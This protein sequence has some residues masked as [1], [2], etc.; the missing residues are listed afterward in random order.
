MH[1]SMCEIVMVPSVAF[2]SRL[3]QNRRPI[4]DFAVDGWIYKEGKYPFLILFFR[5]VSVNTEMN[6][7]IYK[8]VFYMLVQYKIFICAGNFPACDKPTFSTAPTNS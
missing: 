8:R 4:G 3:E 1:S 7:R 2:L 5:F 6:E